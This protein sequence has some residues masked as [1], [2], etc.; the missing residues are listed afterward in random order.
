MNLSCIIGALISRAKDVALALIIALGIG[1]ICIVIA[2]AFVSAVVAEAT[3]LACLGGF[4]LALLVV[5]GLTGLIM[6]MTMVPGIVEECSGGGVTG[7]APGTATGALTT[8]TDCPTA[9]AALQQ[10]QA[11]AAVVQAAVDQQRER[12]R[13]ARRRYQQAMAV[14]GGLA[15]GLAA[16]LL[17]PFEWGHVAALAVALAT[18]LVLVARR[19]AQVARE[20]QALSQ[21][22]DALAAA[23]AQVAGAQALVDSL[24]GQ[25]TPPPTTT[26]GGGF[27]V[28][29]L[30]P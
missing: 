9:Q 2:C 3:F 17:N 19:G 4:L 7:A 23:L 6:L 30:N 20:E 12:V 22:L 18:A 26:V 15:A 24:C 14:A 25:T 10:A 27:N 5:V 1:A 28:A 11:A 13:A 29:R 21:L 16:V 8:P